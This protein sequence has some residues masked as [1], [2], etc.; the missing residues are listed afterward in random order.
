MDWSRYPN[1]S[2][3]E[4]Q[5]KHTGKCEM[6]PEFMAALQD[7]RRQFAKPMNVTSGYRDV[8]HPVEAGKKARGEHTYGLAV[9]IAVSG[10]DALELI[11]LAYLNGFRRV[12]VQQK[13]NGRYIHLGWGDKLAGFPQAMWSY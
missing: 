3:K 11:A 4:F 7:L 5:C 8:T 1:F 10:R 12:G 9:D 2:E 6:H 13:G